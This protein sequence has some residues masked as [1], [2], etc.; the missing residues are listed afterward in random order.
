[1]FQELKLDWGWG[2]VRYI[3]DCLRFV[4]LFNHGLTIDYTEMDE[5][6]SAA[7]GRRFCKETIS[8]KLFPNSCL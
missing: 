8:L 7:L 5:S 6:V 1:M 4:S 2:C 3:L